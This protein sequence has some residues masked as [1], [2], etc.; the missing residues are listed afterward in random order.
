MLRSRGILVDYAVPIHDIPA[1]IQLRGARFALLRIR[2]TH[3]ITDATAPRGV[4][5]A[6]RG[7]AS[8]GVSRGP[9]VAHV[10]DQ[11][12]A[13]RSSLARRRRS[14]SS[15]AKLTATPK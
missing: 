2:T 14:A 7:T 9:H 12:L 1:A 8:V 10:F 4:H 5:A 11:L 3:V 13:T 6:S 15:L